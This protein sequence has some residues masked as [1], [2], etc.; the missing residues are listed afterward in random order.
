[1]ADLADVLV[2]SFSGKGAVLAR[3]VITAVST[4]YLTVRV[5]GNTFTKVP[6]LKGSWTPAVNDNVYLLTQEDFGT[7]ALGSPVQ[8]AA[9][10]PPATPGVATVAPSAVSNYELPPSAYGYTIAE[11][12]SKV[13][14]AFYTPGTWNDRGGVLSQLVALGAPSSSAV[15]FYT[16]ATLAAITFPLASVTMQLQLTSG[17]PVELRLHSDLSPTGL[18]HY[19]L[20]VDSRIYP[21]PL[22]V[23]TTTTTISL[24]LD[25]GKRLIAGTSRGITARSSTTNAVLQAHGSLTFT[26]L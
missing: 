24:P 6:Y 7:L 5:D 15:W 16:P 22:N 3:G 17:G 1:M 8:P 13:P 20:A 18:L 23:G 25:W 2:S 19:Q 26:S 9:P 11:D 4:G 12:G 10:S 14:K 21:L